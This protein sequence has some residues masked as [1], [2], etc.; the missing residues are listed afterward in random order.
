MN[1]AQM[2]RVLSFR[3][4]Q[5]KIA[6][7]EILRA[8]T[9]IILHDKIQQRLHALCSDQGME[10]SARQTDILKSAFQQRWR[11]FDAIARSDAQRLTLA[12]NLI[13]L[14][15][16]CLH[17]VRTEKATQSLY[18]SARRTDAALLESKDLHDSPPRGNVGM[19]LAR[20]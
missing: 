2:Q 1:A 4:V 5:L 10:N 12:Q 15:S 6:H 7:S 9:K 8:Q 11:I 3:K 13:S 17:A 20:Q 19:P 14:K 16:T 18:E